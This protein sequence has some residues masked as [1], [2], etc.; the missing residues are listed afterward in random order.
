MANSILGNWCYLLNVIFL[1]YCNI[2]QFLYL[3]IK[4]ISVIIPTWA[5]QCFNSLWCSMTMRI[6][7]MLLIKCFLMQHGCLFG[8]I[9]LITKLALSFVLAEETESIA[10][11]VAIFYNHRKLHQRLFTV[12]SYKIKLSLTNYIIDLSNA[13][14][15]YFLLSY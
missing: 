2:L 9:F 13:W 5:K 6:V 14:F 12:K 7:T 3:I 11:N 15:C 8:I 4:F 1:S 10:Y